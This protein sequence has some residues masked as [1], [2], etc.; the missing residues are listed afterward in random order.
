MFGI[1][2]FSTLYHR[3]SFHIFMGKTRRHVANLN[4]PCVVW[5]TQSLF[6]LTT[7][8]GERAVVPVALAFED[9]RFLSLFYSGFFVSSNFPFVPESRL[10]STPMEGRSWAWAWVLSGKPQ[11]LMKPSAAL[12]SNWSPVS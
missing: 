6:N 5:F 10:P 2:A 11:S 4:L 8:D 12:W 1:R 3:Q 9:R 7:G